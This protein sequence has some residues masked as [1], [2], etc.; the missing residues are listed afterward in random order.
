MK[1]ALTSSNNDAQTIYNQLRQLNTN[2]TDL[3]EKYDRDLADRDQR[4]DVLQNERNQLLL[5]TN[6]TLHQCQ[7][8]N[9]QYSY[10]IE[11]YRS[12]LDKLQIELEDK[13][14]V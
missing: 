6:E 7:E 4:I 3:Q 11:T 8:K 10:E 13:Q 12:T 2:I 5:K 1:L 9:K 14:N